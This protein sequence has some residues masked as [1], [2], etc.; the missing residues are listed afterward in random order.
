MAE[1]GLCFKAVVAAVEAD[2]LL[3]VLEQPVV[4]ARFCRAL[5]C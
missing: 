4:G 3:V 1:R 2:G 5:G